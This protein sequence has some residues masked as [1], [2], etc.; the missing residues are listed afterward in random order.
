MRIQLWSYLYSPEPTGIGPVSGL[1]ARTLQD[2]GHDVQVVAA[3][4]HYPEPRW[5]KRRLPYREVHDGVDVLRLP[6]WVG[7]GTAAQRIRQELTFTSSLMAALPFV[8]PADVVIAASPCFPALLPAVINSRARRVPLVLWLHD[9]LPDGA[10]VTGLV[11]EGGPVL[12]ASRWLERT[13]YEHA[14]RIVVLSRPFLDNLR[15]KG[16]PDEKLDLIYDPAT[17][18]PGRGAAGDEVSKV[19]GLMVCI[20]NIG[21]TQGLPPLVGEFDRSA[22]L[23]ALGARLV[24]TGTGVAENDVKREITSDAVEMP[25]L[26]SDGELDRLL[27]SATL[28]MVGQQYEGTEFNLPSKIMNYMEY[29]L[30]IVAA[31]NPDGEVARLIQEAG[32]G[33]IADSSKPDDFVRTVKIALGD[34]KER[35]VRGRAGYDFAQSH[36]TREAF[37]A[38]FD[39]LLRETV[40]A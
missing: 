19:E 38:R 28:A 35:A 32:A 15:E 20:G 31:V 13:A 11:D 3:H 4:P 21:H 2:L 14:D 34:A 17:R 22:E 12:R 8:G 29:G 5:G 36:F 23:R 39:L 37:G 16:V 9:L 26:V 25:G 6:L 27:R 7:R 30:P 18:V 1:L 40:L 33:W 10:L 24:I